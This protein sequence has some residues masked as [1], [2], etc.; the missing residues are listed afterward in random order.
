MVVYDAHIVMVEQCFQNMV[1]SDGKLTT[2]TTTKAKQFA[3][4]SKY[5]N[6]YLWHFYGILLLPTIMVLLYK[7][8]KQTWHI[9]VYI[10]K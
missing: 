2:T 7:I 5:G 4:L 3:T 1:R 8:Y 6:S 9:G 10:V